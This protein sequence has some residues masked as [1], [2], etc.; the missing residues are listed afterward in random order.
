MSTCTRCQQAG[1]GHISRGSNDR[2]P[3]MAVCIVV[4]VVH[5]HTQPELQLNSRFAC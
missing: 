4:L 1:S 5:V 2:G 3:E